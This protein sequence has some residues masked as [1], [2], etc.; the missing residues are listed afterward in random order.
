M[1]ILGI[2]PGLNFTGWGIIDV[3]NS[4]V[5]FIDCGI[6]NPSKKECD[7]KRLHKIYEG[8]KEVV[9]A[10]SPEVVSIEETFVNK[11]PQGALKLGYAR[12]IALMIPSIYNLEV[13]EYAPTVVKKTV[14][15]NGHASKEQVKV[16]L[17]F[18]MPNIKEI[19]DDAIDALS[20]ALCHSYCKHL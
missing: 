16:M 6:I 19:K 13:F 3:N 11:N 17:K 2:D 5:K 20:I 18:I 9:T 15:G 14:S 4:S 8:L 1:R 12:G 7:S 10:F